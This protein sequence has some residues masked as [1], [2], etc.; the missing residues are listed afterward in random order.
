MTDSFNKVDKENLSNNMGKKEFEKEL[1]TAN[2]E[3]AELQKANKKLNQEQLESAT[4]IEK[5]KAQIAQL[6]N[7]KKHGIEEA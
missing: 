5:L 1:E 3:K 2:T 7:D 6:E 4:E